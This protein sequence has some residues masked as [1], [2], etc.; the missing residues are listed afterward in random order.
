MSMIYNFALFSDLHLEKEKFFEIKRPIRQNTILLLAGDIGSPFK[1]SYL[2][3]LQKC[4]EFYF[5]TI[6][7]KGNHECYGSTLY[8]T[9]IIISNIVSQFHNVIYLN[10]KVFD[11]PHSDIRVLGCTLWC[12]I[13]KDQEK[14][15]RHHLNDFRKIKDFMLEDYRLEHLKDVEF[16]EKTILDCKKDHKRAI[17]LTHHSPYLVGTSHPKYDNDSINS[18]FSTDLSYLM[19]YPVNVWAFG[20]THYS[21][22]ILDRSGTLII[23]N[24]KGCIHDKTTGF[25]PKPHMF[26]LTL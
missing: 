25:T 6:L 26:S 20:H 8:D 19:G 7:I 18:T 3:F 5:L 22:C 11:I 23:S 4:S 1:E 14:K 16:I 24:Q 17:V 15:A 13:S 10:R 21:C 12:F 9:D 2:K